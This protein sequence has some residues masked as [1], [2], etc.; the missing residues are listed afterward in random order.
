MQSPKFN[1][2]LKEIIDQYS[3]I[4]L[5]DFLSDRLGIP[6]DKAEEL[7]R[8]IEKECNL[9]T[10]ATTD[11]N[12]EKTFVE[13]TEAL[14]PSKASA[15]SVESLSEKEFDRFIK[16]LLEELGYEVQIGKHSSDSG[17]DFLAVKDGE[18][19]SIQAARYPK[20][21]LVSSSTVLKSHQ[22]KRSSGCERVIVLAT[23]YFSEQAKLDAQNLNLNFGTAIL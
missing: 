18:K 12:V 20:T 15:Y 5:V 22:A 14:P 6:L 1:G 17:I 4:D 8:R 3:N 19:V 7:A 21:E 13:K 11:A 9:K 16:W 2:V 23:A 10:I